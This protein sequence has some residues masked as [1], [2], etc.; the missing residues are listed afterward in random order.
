[1]P[2]VSRFFGIII[3]MFYVRHTAFRIIN[4]ILQQA[5]GMLATHADVNSFVE[6]L[7]YRS[8]MS[9]QDRSS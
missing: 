3:R 4:M 6:D 9:M 5:G 1:M 2:E 7:R 8:A